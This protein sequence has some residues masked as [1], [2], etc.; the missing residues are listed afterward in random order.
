MHNIPSSIFLGVGR[1]AQGGVQD[2]VTVGGVVSTNR[3]GIHLH[4]QLEQGKPTA[5]I[6]GPLNKM[7]LE[8]PIG[9][10]GFVDEPTL[11]ILVS[12]VHYVQVHKVAATSL[13]IHLDLDSCIVIMEPQ[14]S[15]HEWIDLVIEESYMSSMVG[16]VV[17]T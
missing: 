12:F 5:L 2:F 14:E 11:Q 6:E 1:E 9:D 16:D 10:N 3:V 7:A 15:T 17:P 13:T 4:G 8:A